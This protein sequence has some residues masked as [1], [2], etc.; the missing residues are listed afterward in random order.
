MTFL[1]ISSSCFVFCKRTQPLTL[2]ATSRLSFLPPL[3]C[4]H[5]LF[6]CLLLVARPFSCVAYRRYSSLRT[7]RPRFSP[8]PLHHLCFTRTL[9]VLFMSLGSAAI[10]T[11]RSSTTRRQEISDIRRIRYGICAF[12]C[13]F[14]T[15]DIYVDAEEGMPPPRR[16]QVRA[17]L[18]LADCPHD[19]W[20]VNSGS[21]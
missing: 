8:H 6:S 7:D 9:R 5:L 15:V 20:N 16:E 1:T 12:L 4:V 21:A 18:P 17:T 2:H 3:P 11:L 14:A 19:L 13:S 10:H